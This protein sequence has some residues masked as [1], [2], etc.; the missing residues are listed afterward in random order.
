[1]SDGRHHEEPGLS[2]VE[3]LDPVCVLHAGLRVSQE[4]LLVSPAHRALAQVIVPL[5]QVQVS[6][7]VLEA[8]VLGLRHLPLEVAQRDDGQA[9]E[10]EEGRR[11]GV[12]P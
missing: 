8:A 4:L 1:M 10:Q 3:T 12:P 11:G 9:G 5:G 2:C 6:F 7:D